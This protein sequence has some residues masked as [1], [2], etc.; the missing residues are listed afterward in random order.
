MPAL[1]L[2]L[3]A[4]VTGLGC[5][6]PGPPQPP[7]EEVPET[8]AD[9]RAQQAGRAIV[10]QFTLPLRSTGGARLR[11]PRRVEIYREFLPAGPPPRAA[12]A[13]PGPE[14]A[15]GSPPLASPAYT[16]DAS[17][18]ASARVGDAVVFRDQLSEAEFQEH[19]GSRAIYRVRTAAAAGNWSRESAPATVTLA[20][21]PA[22]VNGLIASVAPGRVTLQWSP[23]LAGNGPAAQYFAVYREALSPAT[24]SANAPVAI[25]TTTG[26]SYQDAAVRPGR[27]YRYAV[28]SISSAP[29]GE[30]ESAAATVLAAVP[31]LPEPGPPADVV[32]IPIQLP[33]GAPEVELSWAI[34]GARNLAGYNV[35]RSERP[36]G[37]AVRLNATPLASAAFRD[38]T[39][40][41]G[42]EYGYAV[43]SVDLSG[44]ESRPSAPVMV[45][46]PATNREVS[47]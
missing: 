23:P 5:A 15:G 41:A 47:E 46:V 12:A 31:P 1:L 38:A 37:R 40:I 19:R 3:A 36:G 45:T 9:L 13:R 16:L 17:Q 26:T 35:Y 6:A 8:V 27:Q 22:P 30:V 32:A 33:T 4:L 34:G 18:L 39:V 25:G 24:A 2:L 11:G 7:A 44:K 21:P 14:S 29:G 20:V 42:R 10:L 43:T 28:R